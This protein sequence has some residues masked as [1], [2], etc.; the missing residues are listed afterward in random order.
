[1]SCL[2]S[3]IIGGTITT[4]IKIRDIWRG[5]HQARI[6]QSYG[7]TEA[8]LCSVH[9][10]NDAQSLKKKAYS[11]GRVIC[12]VVI[13]VRDIKTKE[14]LHPNELGEIFIHSEGMMTKYYND[15]DLTK[16]SF[17]SDGLFKTQDV[18]S[19]DMFEHL[20]LQVSVSCKPKKRIIM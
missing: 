8:G 5:F 12:G 15:P 18:G 19:Y 10:I 6:Y 9:C 3:M 17:T 1:M 4:P 11:S 13:A 2:K 20:Y 7:L 14:S 16:K